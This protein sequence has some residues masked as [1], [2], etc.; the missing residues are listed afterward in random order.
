MD[1]KPIV[2]AKGRRSYVTS[3]ADG[4]S[5]G[6]YMLMGYLPPI[7]AIPETNLQVEYFGERYPIT[8]K[9]V[10]N[11]PLYDPENSKLKD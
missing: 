2:D 6:K 9:A 7:Y 3:A 11:S 4:P 10:G 5:I 1:G 8:V